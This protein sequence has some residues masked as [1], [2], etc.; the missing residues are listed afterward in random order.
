MS[1]Q[2]AFAL[3]P[4]RIGSTLLMILGGLG[5]L[6]AMTGLHGIVSYTTSRRTFEIGIRKALGA[7]R[8][9][10]VRTV[11]WDALLV[12]GMGSIAGALVSAGLIRIAWPLVTGDQT[13]LTPS[14]LVV[15][16]MVMAAVGAAA[17][18]RPALR[19]ANVDPVIALRHD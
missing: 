15:V 17:A 10:I 14:A 4:A 13:S 18:L 12:V 2:L 11:L 3:L 8:A 19:A 16:F 1:D 5:L 9:D 6:L 7:R